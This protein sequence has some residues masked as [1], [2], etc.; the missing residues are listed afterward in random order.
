MRF[1]WG[2]QAIKSN[3]RAIKNSNQEQQSRTLEAEADCQAGRGI[4][5]AASAMT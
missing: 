1:E 5:R 3:P 2:C 4:V